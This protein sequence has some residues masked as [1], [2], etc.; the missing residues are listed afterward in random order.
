[1]V[2]WVLGLVAVLAA[3]VALGHGALGAPALGAPHTWG[4]WLAE[5]TAADAA[6]AIVRLVVIGLAGYLL[7]VTVLAV[8]LRLGQAGRLVTAVDVV[9][10]P[11]VRGVVQAALGVGLT[12]VAVATVGSTGVHRSPG[13]A[14][15]AADAALVSSVSSGAVMQRLPADG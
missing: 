7:A 11:L 3:M 8:V 10:L 15:T 12:G 4:D 1:M 14:P 9:T 5:R 2:A 13:G 6:M